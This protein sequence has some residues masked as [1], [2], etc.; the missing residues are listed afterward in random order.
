M[1]N[2]FSNL[3]TTRTRRFSASCANNPVL[4]NQSPGSPCLAPRVSQLRQEECADLNLR[5]L[6]HEREIQTQIQI[7]QSCDDLTLFAE[8]WSVKSHDD[9]SNPLHVTLPS[10]NSACSSP[11]PTR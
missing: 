11:S 10:L 6:N 8:N 4:L 7:S 3:F 5:E 2:N 9:L 1:T